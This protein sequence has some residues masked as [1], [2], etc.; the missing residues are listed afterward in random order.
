VLD[1][2]NNIDTIKKNTVTLIVASKEVGVV[3]V[4]KSKYMVQSCHQN[5]GRNRD[6]KIAKRSFKNVTKFRYLGTTV[7]N[8]NLIKKEIRRRLKSGNAYCHSALN[9]LS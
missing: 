7:R 6:I 2:V 3:N 1:D 9:L 5:V 4:E 8:Q